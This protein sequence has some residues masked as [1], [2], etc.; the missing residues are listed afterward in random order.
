MYMPLKTFIKNSS[1]FHQYRDWTLFS[2]ASTR[3][4]CMLQKRYR[5]TSKPFHLYRDWTLS[6]CY[7]IKTNIYIYIDSLC[8]HNIVINKAYS[9][10]ERN[11]NKTIW[12]G[13]FLWRYNVDFLRR[14]VDILLL[15]YVIAMT[16]QYNIVQQLGSLNNVLAFILCDFK[17]SC[18][19]DEKFVSLFYIFHEWF[20]NGN[21]YKDLVP[22]NIANR[23]QKKHTFY[24]YPL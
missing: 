12:N 15:K 6:S 2:G 10:I 21:I 8:V 14:K 4:T 20:E 11:K 13:G 23:K 16:A 9:F 5:N 22:F 19:M 1:L 17:H 24:I 3:C 7:I 18:L